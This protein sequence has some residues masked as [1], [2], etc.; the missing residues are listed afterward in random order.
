[1]LDRL[2][3]LGSLGDWVRPLWAF[4]CD[5]RFGPGTSFLVPY[6]AGWSGREIER[7]LRGRG[8]RTW[9]LM[10]V[11]DTIIFE[12]ARKQARHAAV[13]LRIA[14]IPFNAGPYA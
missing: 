4:I 5:W 2:L 14:G 6:G 11:G 7:L 12:V 9:G 10:I 13:V 1:M 3:W 8:I